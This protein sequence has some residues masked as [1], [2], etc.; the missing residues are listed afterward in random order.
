[1]LSFL[2]KLVNLAAIVSVISSG[3]MTYQGLKMA[4]RLSEGEFSR[5]TI[6]LMVTIGVALIAV[7]MSLLFVNL[8]PKSEPAA[9]KKIL[10]LAIGVSPMIFFGQTVWSIIGL[11]GTPA[12]AHHMNLTVQDCR[13]QLNHLNG[14][15]EADKNMEYGIKNLAGQFSLLQ[16]AEENGYLSSYKGV[17]NVTIQLDVISKS[18]YSI[19]ESIEE[20]YKE[21]SEDLTQASEQIGE[22]EKMVDDPSL[23]IFKKMAKFSKMLSEVNRLFLKVNNLKIS[24]V[25]R[26]VNQKLGELSSIQEPAGNGDI[27]NKQRE[28]I[29]KLGA[30]IK[31]AQ[32]I[33]S[34][35]V[36]TAEGESDDMR[37]GT[38]M[39][40]NISY[41]V[42]KYWDRIV[43][44]IV[45]AIS[46]DFS[47][48]L[49]AFFLLLGKPVM[50]AEEDE[51]KRRTI[52]SLSSSK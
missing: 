3:M 8:Y 38:M 18:L 40:I 12:M 49:F 25:V 20:A 33:I 9:R 17:G 35:L 45:I 15:I 22:L 32:S 23:D 43:S 31:S 42:L 52:D 37:I 10:Y 30:T 11:G 7:A 36:K 16:K 13:Q 26:Q 46:I 6:P 51:R 4:S 41:A 2:K 24:E 50:A 29:S 19:S 27:A 28:A 21:R 39:N 1:M 14:V 5:E 48:Y 34:G 47:P 44:E